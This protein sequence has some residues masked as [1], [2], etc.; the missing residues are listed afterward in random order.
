MGEQGTHGKNLKYSPNHQH[1]EVSYLP[2]H[3]FSSFTISFSGYFLGVS[4]P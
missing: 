3:I 1:E 4:R 2:A